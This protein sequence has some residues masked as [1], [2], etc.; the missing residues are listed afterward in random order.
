MLVS[1][2]VPIILPLILISILIF[3]NPGLLS[4]WWKLNPTNT[5]MSYSV[6]PGKRGTGRL[7]AVVAYL[8]DCYWLVLIYAQQYLVYS[9]QRS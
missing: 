7:R 9:T 3:K 4:F 5:D 1:S 8:Q 6:T 2:F